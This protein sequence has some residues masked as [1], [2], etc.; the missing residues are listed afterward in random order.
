MKFPS[1]M[2]AANR[3]SKHWLALRLDKNLWR[4]G[5][6]TSGEG[7]SRRSSGTY[8]RNG[9]KAA[10]CDGNRSA[11][12]C[13]HQ[14]HGSRRAKYFY[15]DRDSAYVWHS[16]VSTRM[17]YPP[18]FL[19]WRPQI[20]FQSNLKGHVSSSCSPDWSHCNLMPWVARVGRC[21]LCVLKHKSN[22]VF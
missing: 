7:A 2:H 18:S 14:G 4:F 6:S 1:S 9:C 13:R 11:S 3:K 15:T 19:A 17:S 22:F 16:G 5:K 12:I 20:C 10:V 8:S 21:C